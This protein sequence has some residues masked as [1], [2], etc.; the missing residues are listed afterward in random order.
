MQEFGSK[1]RGKQLSGEDERLESRKYHLH[2]VIIWD[3]FNSKEGG[4]VVGTYAGPPFLG[5]HPTRLPIVRVRT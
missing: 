5:T 3:A 4:Y 2:V 1:F